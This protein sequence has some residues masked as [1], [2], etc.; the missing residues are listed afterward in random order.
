MRRP[1]RPSA[2]FP[3]IDSW[4]PLL[5]APAELTQS[6]REIFATI[7]A[8]TKTDHFREADVPLIALYCQA[9]ELAQQTGAD[10]AKDPAN[11]PAPLLKAYELASRRVLGLSQ[12]LRLSPQARSPNVSQR[13]ADA[14]RQASYY[15][16][17]NA[18]GGQFPGWEDS[19]Q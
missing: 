12:R 18:G 15:D 9:L 10:V 19:D 3:A 11:A 4:R 14:G 16:R 13:S 5:Q 17:V 1:G 7:T 6:Q 2:T 8:T